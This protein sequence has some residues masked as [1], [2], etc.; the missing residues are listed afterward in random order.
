MLI[1]S[2]GGGLEISLTGSGFNGDNT[3]VSICDNPC[4]ISGNTN[5]F[6]QVTCK[7]YFFIILNFKYY[8]YFINVKMTNFF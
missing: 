7:V 3:V 4:T 5:T 2:Y 1:G 6:S 8:L